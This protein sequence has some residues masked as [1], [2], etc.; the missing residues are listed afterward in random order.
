M[1]STTVSSPWMNMNALNGD[2]AAPMSRRGVTPSRDD[3]GDRTEWLHRLGPDRAVV[4]WV[5]FVEHGE[6]VRVLLPIEITTVDDDAAD[7]RPVA[8]D[9]LRRRV[10]GDRGAVPD[11]LAQNRA[12]GVVHDERH[13]ELA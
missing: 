2:M 10:H 7:R 12:R 1:R 4:A 5:R 3:V 8:A 13:A 6:T 9:V 11:G